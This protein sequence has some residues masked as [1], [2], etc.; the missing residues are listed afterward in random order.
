MQKDE[1]LL[2]ASKAT[3]KKQGEGNISEE[4]TK[5]TRS[6]RLDLRSRQLSRVVI[7]LSLSPRFAVT[8]SRG[9]KENLKE[10]ETVSKNANPTR[11]YRVQIAAVESR[12]AANKIPKLEGQESSLECLLA[13]QKYVAA[14]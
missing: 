14:E 11:G 5:T 12:N 4:R 2:H 7:V 8:Y 13:Q 1:Q 9:D 6:C 10:K 3:T